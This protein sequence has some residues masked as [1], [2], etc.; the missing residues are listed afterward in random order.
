MAA[1]TCCSAMLGRASRRSAWSLCTARTRASKCSL[2][3]AVRTSTPAAWRSTRCTGVAR[4]ASKPRTSACTYCRAPP[5]T[6][7]HSGRW[8]TWIRPW[9]WQKR[10]MV[11]T[12]KRS[13]WSVGQLQM[14]PSM[15]RK[16]Q[17]RN[18]V[19]KP[20]W[21][22]K[23]PSGC[24]SASSPPR[25]AK[26]VHSR[27]K[28]SSSASMPRKRGRSRLRRCANTVARLEPLHSSAPSPQGPAPGTCTEKDMSDATVGT[29]SASNSAIRPG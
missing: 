23:S 21:S 9:L 18:A 20:C 12:G 14:Q 28:R 24:A 1:S 11:A 6:V 29:S 7:R 3:A 16:Y 8:F 15:G 5:C 17:W 10:T 26:A 4:R 2:P 27:L 13:I 22:R 25:S 19:L